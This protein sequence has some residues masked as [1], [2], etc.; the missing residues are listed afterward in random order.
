MPNTALLTVHGM[1]AT[2]REYAVKLFEAVAA[3]LGPLAGQV[4]F[5]S[6]YYQ[7]ILKPNQETVWS[8]VSETT[9][10]RYADLRRFLLFGFGD[11]AGLENRKEIE[12]SVYEL[13]QEAIARQL[14]E[15]A[16]RD[17]SASVVFL[18]QSLGCQVLSSYVYDAQKAMASL[19]VPAGI[20]KD[21]DAWSLR[22]LGERL[23][24][25]EKRFL[26]GGTCSAFVTTGCN[27]PIFCAAHKQ[28]DIRPIARP[29][30]RFEW[31]N[32]YDPDDALGWPLQPLSPG[33][34]ALV[35]DRAINAGQGVVTWILK[36]W[37]PL[38]HTAY[39][40][41]AQ[42]LDLVTQRLRIEVA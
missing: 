35:D 29:T 38:S 27:I 19:I 22:A 10:L 11:A 16:R 13:A 40:G 9:H 32:L 3:R 28:M 12:G 24:E 15:V 37:N 6:I 26:A 23:S 41:D 31:I 42:V 2:P 7:D 34:A 25:P 33:Y 39:W 36:S 17:R 18:A 14:L 30:E 20:W 8:R 4:D 5:R 1:G 21:I